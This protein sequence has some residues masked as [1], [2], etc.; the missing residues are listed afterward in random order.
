MKVLSKQGH[1]VTMAGANKLIVG[2]MDLAADVNQNV[3]KGSRMGLSCH[4]VCVMFWVSVPSGR[5]DRQIY[6]ILCW[7]KNM[8]YYA[9]STCEPHH[10]YS[11]F[12]EGCLT[13][14]I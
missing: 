9:K 13:L 2:V 12:V 5:P 3:F 11:K 6:L 7:S 1:M 8:N 10:K 14:I 4:F